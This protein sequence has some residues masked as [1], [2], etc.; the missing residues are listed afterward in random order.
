MWS[1]DYILNSAYSPRRVEQQ[2]PKSQ[3]RNTFEDLLAL[4]ANGEMMTAENR[5]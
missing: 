1:V 3:Y 5:S 4:E 2:L